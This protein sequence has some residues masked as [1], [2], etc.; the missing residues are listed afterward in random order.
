MK[1][2]IINFHV[3]S[4]QLNHFCAALANKA[5]KMESSFLGTAVICCS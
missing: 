4:E 3:S 2:N 1:V 5:L